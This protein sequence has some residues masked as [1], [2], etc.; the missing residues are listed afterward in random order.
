M[1]NKTKIFRAIGIGN[2]ILATGIVLNCLINKKKSC[3]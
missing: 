3:K 1:F 2:I